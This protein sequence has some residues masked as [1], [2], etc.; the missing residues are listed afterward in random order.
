M[1]L[2]LFLAK[3]KKNGGMNMKKLLKIVT[4][5]ASMFLLGGF[6]TG[7]KHL[8]NDSTNK[9]Y[10]EPESD[11]EDS[12]YSARHCFPDSYGGGDNGGGG[13]MSTTSTFNGGF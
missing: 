1:V 5:T 3:N 12:E 7:C 8:L 13:T 10:S 2:C 6:F 9:N 4:L 11:L